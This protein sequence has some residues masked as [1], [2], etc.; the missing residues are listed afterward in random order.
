MVGDGARS[1]RAA[2]DG[3]IAFSCAPR[4]LRPAASTAAVW[5][6]AAAILQRRLELSARCTSLLVTARAL[7]VRPLTGSSR[8]SK[9]PPSRCSRDAAAHGAVRALLAPAVPPHPMRRCGARPPLF[10][11]G[12]SGSPRGARRGRL[13]RALSACGRWRGRRVLRGGRRLVALAALLHAAS[14]VRSSRPSFR[15]IRR[16]EVALGRR[17]Y[18]VAVLALVAVHVE[19]GDSIRAL[20]TAADEVV[21]PF[22]AFTF[23]LLSRRRCTRRRS[24]A[25]R[26]RNSVASD[27]IM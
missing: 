16:G 9:R 25:S 11:G 18:A 17:S 26:V 8:L 7:C 27:A 22:G 6:S 23:A 2:A 13:Q 5:R 19:V 20:R 24:C 3:V 4:A 14:L 15:R 12:G 1:L 21:A 10:C